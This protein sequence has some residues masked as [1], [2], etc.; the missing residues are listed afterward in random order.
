MATNIMQPCGIAK[1]MSAIFKVPLE[2]SYAAAG[3]FCC[4]VCGKASTNEYYPYCTLQHQRKGEGLGPLGA[5]YIDMIC[6]VCEVTF[7]RPLSHITRSAKSRDKRNQMGEYKV[8]C[9]NKCQGAW[10]GE[11][12]GV[13]TRGFAGHGRNKTHCKH[14]HEFTIANIY[15]M[16]NGGRQCRECVKRRSF[17][18]QCRQ[19]ALTNNAQQRPAAIHCAD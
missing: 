6:D 11:N 4:S 13:Q 10:L 8:F 17:E 1:L 5:I 14:G 3:L 18:Y 7:P 15:R 9:S 12:H 16:K 2:E 19:K